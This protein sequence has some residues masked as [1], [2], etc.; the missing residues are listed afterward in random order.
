[1][2]YRNKVYVAFDADTDMI[3]Y[4]TLQ[5]WSNNGNIDF[6]LNDAHDLNN[7]MKYSNEM[8]IKSKLRERLKNTKKFVLLL[9]VKTKYLYK[10]VRWEIDVAKSLD[11]PIIVCNLNNEIDKDYD[12]C[13]AVLNDTTAIHISFKQKMLKHALDNYDFKPSL[14]GKAYHYQTDFYKRLGCL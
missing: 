3:Y 10:Y 12:R 4:R 8:T 13:P 1:M 5:M 14:D 2:A 7:L 11:I 9:G 6:D